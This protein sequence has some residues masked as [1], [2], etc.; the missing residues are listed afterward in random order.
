LPKIVGVIDI[1]ILGTGDVQITLCQSVM[2]S[3]ACIVTLPHTLSLLDASK[4]V[5]MFNELRVPVLAIVENMA[6]FR[7]DDGKV[8]H[9]FGQGGKEAVKK[10]L[11][12]LPEKQLE[13]VT[14]HSFPISYLLSQ[15]P[16]ETVHQDKV[17]TNCSTGILQH[18]SSEITMEYEALVDGMISSLFK[19]QLSAQLVSSV[20]SPC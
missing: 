14:H 4:G 9:P 20:I 16:S 15:L 13:N 17:V 11:L 19:A 6:Y 10:G 18:P 12:R 5:D 1:I 2:I 7:G 8:Y 3:G